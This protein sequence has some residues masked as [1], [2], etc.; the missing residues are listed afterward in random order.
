VWTADGCDDCSK[1]G[2]AGRR[3][4]FEVMPVASLEMK[5]LLT[6]GRSPEMIAA[7]AAA[8]G[9]STLRRAALDLA[10]AGHISL[11]EAMKL[12]LGD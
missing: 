10:A 11:P 7:Q 12:A 6:D 3:P 4:L 1:T 8:E 9:M 5:R 2:C